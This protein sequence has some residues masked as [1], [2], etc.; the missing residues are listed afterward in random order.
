L[1][2]IPVNVFFFISN[3]KGIEEFGNAVGETF[4]CALGCKHAG[5]GYC[6][7]SGEY[8]QGLFHG[9]GEFKCQLGISYKGQWF[10]G[11]KHGKVC[12]LL[13]FRCV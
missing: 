12:I 2:I 4:V 8:R 10:R 3:G 11:K 6:T 5:G 13:L 7:Y 9:F 1:L